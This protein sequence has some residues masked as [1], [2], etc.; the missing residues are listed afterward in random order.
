MGSQVMHLLTGEKRYAVCGSH[1]EIVRTYDTYIA[2]CGLECEDIA[3][4]T[5]MPDNTTCDLCKQTEA[6][7]E[8]C[9]E[10]QLGH[11]R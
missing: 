6:Y 7:Y 2:A 4:V 5:H 8:T 1:G 9:I 11:L 10:F 3:D